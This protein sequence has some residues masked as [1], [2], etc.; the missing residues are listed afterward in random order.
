MALFGI[1][2]KKGNGGMMNVIR[3][4]EPEYLVWK[5][6]PSGEANTTT[7]ENAIRWG[8]S[9]RVKDG[10]VAVFVY[11]QKDGSM[12]DFIEGPFD[13]TIKTANFPVL[14]SII[15]L[16]YGGDTPFQAEVYFIN[17]A[18]V[19]QIKFGVPYFDVYDPRF[20]DF[21]VPMSV[22][23]TLTFNIVD[24]KDF[25]KKHRL[26]NFSLED[27]NTQ[28]KDAVVKRVKS[29]VANAPTDYQIPV[30]Q[31][32]RR[33]ADI[34]DI[35]LEKVK[36][37]LA[38]DFG[39]AVKRFDVAT[40]DVDKE[41]DGYTE[42]RRVTAA[43]QEKTITAQTD[44]SIQNLQDTQ[45]INAQNMEETLR[46]QREEAQRAQ[47]LQTETNFMGAH[48]LDQQTEVMRTGMQSLGSMTNMG[49]GG[50]MNPAGMMTGMMMGGALGGQMAGMMNQMGGTMQQAM[51]TPPPAPTS[52][53]YVAVNGQQSGPYSVAQLQQ[54]AAAG[55]FT[56]QSMVWK[57]GMAAWDM[58][59]NV[60]ELAAIF[61]PAT[62]P[63]PPVP[64]AF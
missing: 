36:A 22:R 4:D 42:L 40:I 24:Y 26:I 6:R 50:G 20:L 59:S 2:N 17:L 23:G 34:S 21:G 41:S 60:A 31:I 46:I 14:S 33:I 8:S 55:Q 37:D 12:Q 57:Q 35:I 54:Y 15:G 19:V 56:P 62:S 64:P 32:E 39:I 9:L 61:A 44:I 47:R 49:G 25:I 5:W 51:N 28:I 38:D 10:E 58:A 63:V 7:R 30:L 52:Q 13:E 27:L 3:C 43:Q 48:A 53:Y 18:G 11:K 45:R 1:G 29:I 16:A